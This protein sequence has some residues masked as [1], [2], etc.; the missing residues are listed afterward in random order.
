MSPDHA[1]A[2]EVIEGD[3]T[4]RDKIKEAVKDVEKVY[5]IAALFRQAGVPDQDYRD[6]SIC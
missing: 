4:D 6:V 1:A 3:I 5:H 2:M